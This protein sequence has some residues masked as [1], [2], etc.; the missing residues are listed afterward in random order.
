MS[1]LDERF[2]AL[3]NT[4]DDSDWLDVRR[5]ARRARLRR[6]VLVAAAAV[7]AIAVVA[8]AFGLQRVVIDF[9]AVKPAPEPVQVD[10]T[11]LGIVGPVYLG[12]DVVPNSARKVMDVRVNGKPR[13][14][15][16]APKRN[17]GFCVLFAGVT[18]SC[19]DRTPPTRHRRPRHPDDLNVYVLGTRGLFDGARVAQI[20]GGTLLDERVETVVADFADGTSLELPITWVSPPIDAGFYFLDIPEAHRAAGSQLVRLVARDRDGDDIARENFPLPKPGDV[21]RPARLPD[22]SLTS[23][24]RKAIVERARKVIS[25]ETTTG[26]EYA[27]WV[28]PTTDGGTCHVSNRQGGCPPVGWRQDVP[29]AGGMGGGG[30]P[31]VFEAGVTPAVAAV[32]LRFED[33]TVKRLQ[34]A[35]GFV[36]GEVTPEHYERGHRLLTTVALDASGRELQRLQHDPSFPGVYPCEKPV[37]IGRGLTACP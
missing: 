3:A 18:S 33:G 27:V 10:F 35:N 2:A 17:G 23:L 14:I 28:M 4:T 11:R 16:A 22:G 32:E 20:I 12:P 24:P 36:L 37:D 1:S 29:M 6:P 21:E 34:P 15:Y 19:R 8:P 7:L 30:R 9:L 31:M 25:I 13:A 26:D 5:R